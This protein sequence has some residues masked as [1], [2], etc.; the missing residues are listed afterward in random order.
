[1]KVENG[2]YVVRPIKAADFFRVVGLIKKL[3]GKVGEDIRNAIKAHNSSSSPKDKDVEDG[4]TQSA[5]S[6]QILIVLYENLESDIVDWFAD[7]C[8]CKVADFMKLPATAPLDV[9]EVLTTRE[10]AKNFLSR[11]SQLL[12]TMWPSAGASTEE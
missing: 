3:K 10:D 9:I 11:A 4:D 1:M 8:G 5:L 2:K 7:L 12:K 6:L